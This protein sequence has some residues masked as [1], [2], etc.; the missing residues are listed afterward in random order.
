MSFCGQKRSFSDTHATAVKRVATDA[1]EVEMKRHDPSK[2]A[3]T[4]KLSTSR[5]GL[6]Q[7]LDSNGFSV[8]LQ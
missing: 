4:L 7:V 8:R 3:M 1:V 6:D 2:S 5:A